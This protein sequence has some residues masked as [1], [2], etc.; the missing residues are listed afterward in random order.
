MKRLSILLLILLLCLSVCTVHAEFSREDYYNM[1]LRA[2]KE[3][4]QDLLEDAM[5]YFNAAGSYQEAKSYRQYIM[6]LQDIFAMDEGE[7]VDLDTTTYRLQV[8]AKK[9]DFEASLAENGLPSCVSLNTYI[10]AR[11]MEESGAYATAWH[12]YEEVDNVLDALDRRIELTPLAYNQGKNAYQ[13]GNYRE[14]A[15]ALQD[16]DYKDSE[17]MF[18]EAYSIVHPTPTPTP[19]PR[20]ATPTPRPATPT[21]RPATPTP[22]P[23]PRRVTATPAPVNTWP[24][25]ATCRVVV[26]EG[27]ARS[28]PGTDYS[29][30]GYIFAGNTFTVLEYRLGNTGK[31]WYRI[32]LSGV[33]AWISSAMVEINGRQGGT[34]NGSPAN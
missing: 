32:N 3:M 14:A 4:D 27:R 19:T 1:G 18:R 34:V 10:T 9:T 13:R 24:V 12:L 17:T 15:D 20:P 25:G 26:N 5:D 21:P 28:G 33:T 2:L 16:L 6:S 22:S 31:D 23:T 11:Q 8:L 30:V 7:A 29:V